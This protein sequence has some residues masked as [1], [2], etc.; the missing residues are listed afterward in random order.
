M[1][2]G[3]PVGASGVLLFF[4]IRDNKFKIRDIQLKDKYIGLKG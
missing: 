1:W 2:G 3:G 4:I